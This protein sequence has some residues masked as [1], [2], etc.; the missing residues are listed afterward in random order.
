MHG[1][2]ALLL[3][4]WLALPCREGIKSTRGWL[5]AAVQALRTSLGCDREE[6]VALLRR[7]RGSAFKAL[8]DALQVG[9][10]VQQGPHACLQGAMFGRLLLPTVNYCELAD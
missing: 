3:W 5:H 7:A 2:P 8:Q 6:G 1:H 10:H 4:G 9:A